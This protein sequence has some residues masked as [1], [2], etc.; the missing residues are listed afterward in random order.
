MKAKP[1]TATHIDALAQRL[2]ETPLEPSASVKKAGDNLARLLDARIG[3]SAPR[4]LSRRSCPPTA[5]V[6]PKPG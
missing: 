6:R 3:A 1:L 2:S 5:L 4:S